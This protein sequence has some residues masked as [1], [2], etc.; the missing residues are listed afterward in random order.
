MF[1]NPD[2]E[3]T[4]YN[5]ITQE[6]HQMIIEEA[7]MRGIDPTELLKRYSGSGRIY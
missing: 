1:T 6:E 7:Q 3:Y 4:S 5:E 2:M